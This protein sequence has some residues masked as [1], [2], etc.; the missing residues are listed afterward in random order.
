MLDHVVA[1]RERG[2]GPSSSIGGG[3]GTAERGETQTAWWTP[4]WSGGRSGGGGGLGGRH[5]GRGR[6]GLPACPLRALLGENRKHPGIPKS[7][8]QMA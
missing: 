8:G 5:P 1:S 6:R 7:E 3:G 4:G 2:V